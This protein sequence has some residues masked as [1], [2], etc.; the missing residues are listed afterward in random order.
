MPPRDPNE[1][2]TRIT[3]DEAKAMID[4]GGVTVVDVRN[5]DEWATGHVPKALLISVDNVIER[6]D[7][8][9]ADKDLLFICAAG[10]R[11]ALA[12]EYAA[13]IASI[14][15]STSRAA[16]RNGSRRVIRL[17]GRRCDRL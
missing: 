8:P 6:E 1:P 7:E 9:A 11:S 14:G 15:S 2:F 3:V 12:A 5:P 10:V 13:A 17:T 4:D 16:R